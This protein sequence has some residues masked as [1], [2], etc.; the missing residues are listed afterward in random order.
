MIVLLREML[1]AVSSSYAPALK[2]PKILACWGSPQPEAISLG[3]HNDHVLYCPL[4]CGML[5]TAAG[6]LFKNPKL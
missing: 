5:R 4:L 2:T 6:A 1:E 3:D